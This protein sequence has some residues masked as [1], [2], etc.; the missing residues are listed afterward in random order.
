[1][2]VAYPQ[3]PPLLLNP[4]A[5]YFLLWDSVKVLSSDM[6]SLTVW[7]FSASKTDSQYL[8]VRLLDFLGL[9]KPQPLLNSFCSIH[10]VFIIHQLNGW[11]RIFWLENV[12]SL[13]AGGKLSEDSGIPEA[14]S[15]YG[16]LARNRC[17]VSNYCFEMKFLW[18]CS[19][20]GLEI[21]V[22][23]GA[24]STGDWCPIYFVTL[25]RAVTAELESFSS[26]ICALTWKLWFV[27]FVTFLGTLGKPC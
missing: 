13:P 26:L 6:T 16:A 5:K 10:F 22:L 18:L 20:C 17:S 21:H 27:I 11:L 23:T 3:F 14:P 25:F 4:P 12:F 9:W 1:M 24:V 7:I 8:W 2:R 19:I 15:W